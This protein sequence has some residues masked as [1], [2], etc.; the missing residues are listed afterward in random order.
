MFLRKS[1]KNISV[2]ILKLMQV[3]LPRIMLMLLQILV[4]PSCC[5]FFMAQPSCIQKE[6]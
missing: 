4:G 5:L 6:N 3:P 1:R 2:L